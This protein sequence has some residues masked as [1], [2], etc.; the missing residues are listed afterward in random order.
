M[1]GLSTERLKA[2][3]EMIRRERKFQMRWN[4][5]QQGEGAC[6]VVGDT[7]ATLA[8]SVDCIGSNP[9]P[10]RYHLDYLQKRRAELAK[11]E[12]I[13]RL[14]LLEKRKIGQKSVVVKPQKEEKAETCAQCVGWKIEERKIPMRITQVEISAPSVR[15]FLRKEI[16]RPNG[17]GVIG[18]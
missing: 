10:C 15:G 2:L 1:A 6:G 13:R 18:T 17:A 8:T 4:Q 11:P 9:D 5:E 14:E 3:N 12:H 16:Y 7:N